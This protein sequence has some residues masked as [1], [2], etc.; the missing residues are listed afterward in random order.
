MLQG[1]M[2]LCSLLLVLLC[3]FLSWRV[4]F[5]VM[6]SGRRLGA[7][8]TG[9]E[10]CLRWRV[11][12]VQEDGDLRSYYRS[13][14][15]YSV[16]KPSFDSLVAAELVHFCTKQKLAAKSMACSP[17]LTSRENVLNFK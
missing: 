9:Q 11:L 16:V 5:G 15:I 17:E 7:S 1:G 3:C 14:L 12:G 8:R 2:W 13:A 4:Y 6:V 10:D